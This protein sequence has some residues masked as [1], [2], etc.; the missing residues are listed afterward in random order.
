MQSKLHNFSFKGHL[1]TQRKCF[2]KSSLFRKQLRGLPIRCYKNPE[3]T[4][5]FELPNSFPLCV[6]YPA[7]KIGIFDS[8]IKMHLDVKTPSFYNKI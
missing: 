5:K 6:I 7:S 4:F 1:L 2:K 8:N 3:R